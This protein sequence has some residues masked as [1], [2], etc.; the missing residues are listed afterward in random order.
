MGLAR[1]P[2]ISVPCI[3]YAVERREAIAGENNYQLI[4]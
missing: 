4:D 1:H 3:E 2:G